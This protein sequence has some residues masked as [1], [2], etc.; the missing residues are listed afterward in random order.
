LANDTECEAVHSAG[1]NETGVRD[2]LL[3]WASQCALRSNC[4]WDLWRDWCVPL[5]SISC[6]LGEATQSDCERIVGCQWTSAGECRGWTWDQLSVCADHDGDSAAC[7]ATLGCAFSNL[8]CQ[9]EEP[10]ELNYGLVSHCR[11]NESTPFDDNPAYQSDCESE[12]CEPNHQPGSGYVCAAHRS[13]GLCETLSLEHCEPRYSTCYYAAAGCTR[14]TFT[15]GYSDDWNPRLVAARR[16]GGGAVLQ[17]EVAMPIYSAPYVA[18]EVDGHSTRESPSTVALSSG[19]TEDAIAASIAAHGLALGQIYSIGSDAPSLVLVANRRYEG[20]NTITYLLNYTLA[21]GFE[22]F[23]RM[24]RTASEFNLTVQVGNSTNSTLLRTFDVGYGN[25]F[26]TAPNSTYVYPRYM[27][28]DGT[29]MGDPRGTAVVHDSATAPGGVL[30]F[31]QWCY[32]EF[33][34]DI[35]PYQTLVINS[36]D[37][38]PTL[39]LV[40]DGQVIGFANG[41]VV[42]VPSSESPTHQYLLG[43]ATNATWIVGSRFATIAAT[44]GLL[45]NGSGGISAFA[46]ATTWNS[47]ELVVW[48]TNATTRSVS[49]VELWCRTSGG[50]VFSHHNL[51]VHAAYP[52]DPV[53]VAAIWLPIT[54][55]M[56]TFSAVAVFSVA[57][58]LGSHQKRV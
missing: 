25:A 10:P 26:W 47:T 48:L 43:V 37:S 31:E 58:P 7:A 5:R 50:Y 17:L 36:S 6:A 39:W 54:W 20:K 19:I 30:V 45:A 28:S 46:S 41:Q 24:E 1:V 2:T 11:T 14:R 27:D 33:A 57:A 4:S 12:W 21:A 16:L 9:V 15:D 13:K 18:V 23:L 49:P 55:A 42:W 29:L 32:P 38:A 52:L 8:K 44:S 51:T 35:Y 3:H 22:P 34:V 53:R 56:A 40:I